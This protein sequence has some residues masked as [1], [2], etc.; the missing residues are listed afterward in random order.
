MFSAFA[1]MPAFS[2]IAN[3]PKVLGMAPYRTQSEHAVTTFLREDQLDR[4]RFETRAPKCLERRLPRPGL[5]EKRHLRWRVRRGYCRAAE[6]PKRT[7]TSCF[8]QDKVI[9]ECP[10]CVRES[11]INER[12]KCGATLECS[13][14]RWTFGQLFMTVFSSSAVGRCKQVTTAAKPANGSRGWEQTDRT[15]MARRTPLFPFNH[16]LLKKPKQ[17]DRAPEQ[18]VLLHDKNS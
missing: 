16:L 14:V 18:N 13:F 2:L 8:E 15:E 12:S 5:G 9:N 4:S 7:P 10:V 3:K 1:C 11:E 6:K 17:S